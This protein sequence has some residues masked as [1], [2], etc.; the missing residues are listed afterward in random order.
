MSTRV[1]SSRLS[2]RDRL[3]PRRPPLRKIAYR[4]FRATML[5]VIV[6]SLIVPFL[7]MVLSSF[8]S[9]LDI[10]DPSR[11]FDFTPTL[12]NFETVFAT[13]DFLP[14][15]WNSFL[16]GAVSTVLSIA[17][18][19]P[20]AWVMARFQMTK[21]SS[22]VLVARIIPTISLL[23]PWYYVFARIGLVGTY[24]S[25]VL[26]HMF[27]SVPLILWIMLAYFESSPV[28]LEE[29]AEVDG[30]TPIGAFFR[31]TLRLATPGIATASILA[32]IFSWNN[33]MFA[34][35]L[36]GQSTRTLPVAL[37][38]F[39][40]YASIDWGG[41]MAASVVITVPVVFIGV[42]AQRFIVAGLTAGATKG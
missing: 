30:L 36:S 14:F 16:I 12:S 33:F 37:Y 9:N 6:I 18:A 28:E 11:L 38:N 39:I 8:K 22:G 20:A 29:A 15:I 10:T 23:I 40:S 31:I 13:H 24:T 21:S 5:I 17:I 41:L 1:R 7:W 2:A 27:V 25:L 34:L 4:G 19:V 3:M 32:F 26:A 42:F 35:I